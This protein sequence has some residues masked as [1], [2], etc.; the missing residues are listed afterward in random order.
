MYDIDFAMNSRS[1]LA[2]KIAEC[3]AESAEVEFVLACALGVLI[4]GNGKIGLTMYTDATTR[5]AQ[6]AMVKSAARQRR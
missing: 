4:G 1:A 6:M 5:T 3:I 2:T